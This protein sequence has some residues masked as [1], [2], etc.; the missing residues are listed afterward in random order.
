MAFETG[1]YNAVPNMGT[2]VCNAHRYEP[3]T[4]N[5][6]EHGVGWRDEKSIK[7]SDCASELLVF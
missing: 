2:I 4:S 3:C 5:G 6:E 1:W 7:I